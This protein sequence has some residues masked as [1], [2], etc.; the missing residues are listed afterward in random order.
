MPATA[1]DIFTILHDVKDPELPMVDIVE[2]GIVRKVH[3]TSE[4]VQVDITPTYSGCPAMQVIEEDIVTTLH[5]HHIPNV[6]VRTV[7][8][9]AW[10]TDW[11]SAETK[12]KLRQGG[13]APPGRVERE[14]L[15]TL[16]RARHIIAC[17]YCGSTATEER[18][19]FGSTACKAIYYC[20]SCQQPFDRFKEL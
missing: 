9:P 5:A 11:L 16:T 18:S 20:T 3:V 14:A 19:E 17:P 10:T 15:V 6:T 2:L 12:E 13:V 4:Q 7:Y 8:A 1:D